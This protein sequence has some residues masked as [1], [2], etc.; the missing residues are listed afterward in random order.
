MAKLNDQQIQQAFAAHL[1]PGETLRHWAFGVKQPSILLM[2]PLF[3]LALLPGLIAIFILTRNY[4]IAVTDSRFIVLRVK[5]ISNA[6]IKEVMEYGLDELTNG[7]VKTSTG[8]LF[9]HIKIASDTKPFVAK[10]HRAFSK[11]NRPHA[12]AIAETIS[13]A[14]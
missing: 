11:D 1:H 5:S 3:A 2:L 10:F 8:P 6:E 4:L 12:I 9:T 7:S 14:S 13:P